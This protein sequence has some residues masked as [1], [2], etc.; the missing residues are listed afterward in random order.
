VAVFCCAFPRQAEH[1]VSDPVSAAA[2][3]ERCRL[4]SLL[5]RLTDSRM[6][7][8]CAEGM[9]LQ[10]G[11]SAEEDH[12]MTRL[13]LPSYALR[14]R[15]RRES[16]SAHNIS[17]PLVLENLDQRIVLSGMP[18]A[19]CLDTPA[20]VASEVQPAVPESTEATEDLA[21]VAAVYLADDGV[22]HVQ[23]AVGE[24]N[25]VVRQFVDYQMQEVIEVEFAGEW[26][27]IPIEQVQ[28][29]RVHQVSADQLL[30][31]AEGVTLPV[32]LIETDVV[33]AAFTETDPMVDDELTEAPLGPPDPTAPP[34]EGEPP[35][36]GDPDPVLSPPVITSFSGTSEAGFWQFTGQVTDDKSVSGLVVSFGGLLDG[37]TATVNQDGIFSF[38]IFLPLST[39]GSVTAI[40][41]DLDDLDSNLAYT[42]I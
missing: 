2:N 18:E 9:R 14:R 15:K 12:T 42:M 25:I 39:I 16:R 31:V 26:T 22:L 35:G 19:V 32:E 4:E 3:P 29:I 27:A 28:E 23:P 7:M 38:T 1:S 5:S 33:D 17:R 21:A 10:H 37:E 8:F 40:T 24:T 30:S 36:G 20:E 34:A 13:A 11:N 6:L 41:T